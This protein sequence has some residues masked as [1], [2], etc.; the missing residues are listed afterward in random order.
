MSPKVF[1]IGIAIQIVGWPLLYFGVVWFDLWRWR[2]A[3]AAGRHVAHFNELVVAAIAFILI[4]V[5]YPIIRWV[6]QVN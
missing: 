1:W 4:W 6:R 5:L 3:K 2:L